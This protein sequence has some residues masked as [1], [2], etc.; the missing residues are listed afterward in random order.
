[1]GQSSQP[2]FAIFRKQAVKGTIAPDLATAGLGMKLRGGGL[3]PNRELMIPDA[4]IGGGRDVVDAYLGAV[5]WSGDFEFY[6]RMESL[7]TLLQAALGLSTD[8]VQGTGAWKH[9]FT[10]SDAA[11]LPF[12]T[13]QEKVGA[14]L[15]VFNYVDVVVNTLHLEADANGYLQGTVGL[16]G[17]AQTAGVTPD[18]T[19]DM[20]DT[21]MTVGTNIVLTYNAVTL[22]AKSFTLDI[23]NNFEDDDFRLG[24]FFLSQLAPKRREVTASVTI[25]PETSALWRQAVYGAPAATTPGGTV[26]S[27]ELIITAQTYEVI[28]ASA[29]PIT[30]KVVATLPKVLLKPH[31]FD[32]SGD[33]IIETDIE[34]QATR[35]VQAT[36]IG[37]FD[38]YNGLA[39]V[40]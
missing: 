15:E 40:A 20:D 39:T 8:L 9:T 31:S 37:T 18:P 33:D 11:A 3:G 19:P 23:N 25:R 12:Y 34:M 7:A 32:P 21:P 27:Q 30:S 22:P 5:A 35:P 14:S 6:A 1:M 16:I 24:S 4:E 29:P 10:P 26:L 17:A 13:V 28:P 38:V 36:P 2:G